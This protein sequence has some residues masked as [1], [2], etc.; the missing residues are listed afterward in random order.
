M[1][2]DDLLA[3]EN[4]VALIRSS[5]TPIPEYRWLFLLVGYLRGNRV[6][7]LPKDAP[8]VESA[9]A[10]ALEFAR[11]VHAMRKGP[12]DYI[13]WS[14][15]GAVLLEFEA[16]W[17]KR[18]HVLGTDYLER[19][20]ELSKQNPLGLPPSIN[21]WVRRIAN[22]GF[23]LQE[24]QP[25]LPFLIP[26]SEATAKKLGTSLRTLSLAVN[27]AIAAKFLRVEGK[28]P[29]GTVGETNGGRFARRLRFNPRQ[30]QVWFIIE[31]ARDDLAVR[32][33]EESRIAGSEAEYDPFAEAA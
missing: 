23:V 10:A 30:T 29:E 17:R 26:V 16:A 13:D 27:G 6:G 5:P 22:M 31:A 32:L 28:A 24:L 21:P 2:A 25:D 1:E 8:P 20:I 11:R 33:R 12:V 15:D 7:T 18:K 14:D 4:A 19:A 3:V 9:G